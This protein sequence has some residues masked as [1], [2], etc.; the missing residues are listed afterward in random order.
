MTAG[1]SGPPASS[2]AVKWFCWAAGESPRDS[3][4]GMTMSPCA[5]ISRA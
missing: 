4:R 1:S 5:P 3:T 2:M